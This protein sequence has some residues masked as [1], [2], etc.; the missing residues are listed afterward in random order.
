MEHN[1]NL[2]ATFELKCSC[3]VILPRFHLY[4][5]HCS[6]PSHYDNVTLTVRSLVCMCLIF[7]LELR[8]L[9]STKA[10]AVALLSPSLPR[11][12]DYGFRY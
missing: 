4:L 1:E 7:N 11:P 10:A 9:S 5:L 12:R 2:K 6:Q 3:K 8:T